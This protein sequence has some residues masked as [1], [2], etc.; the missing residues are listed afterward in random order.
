M[1]RPR[2]RHRRTRQAGGAALIAVL[3][4]MSGCASSSDREADMNNAAEALEESRNMVESAVTDSGGT[5]TVET[6]VASTKNQFGASDGKSLAIEVYAYVDEPVDEATLTRI[7]ERWV[8]E[9]GYTRGPVEG[10]VTRF[11]K[12]DRTAV[13]GNNAA[14]VGGPGR[15]WFRVTTEFFDPDAA[16]AAVGS[17]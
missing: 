13:V 3:A 5:S 15:T 14:S 17:P 12:G 7:K 8:E 10:D 16:R 2:L 9:F 1:T 6:K 11:T 4:A